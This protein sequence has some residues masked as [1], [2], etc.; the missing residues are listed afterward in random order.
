M[1][2]ERYKMSK[3]WGWAV[4]AFLMLG[5]VGVFAQDTESAVEASET[6]GTTFVEMIRQGGWTMIPLG[7]FSLGTLTFALQNFMALREKKLLRP[8]LMPTLR[9]QMA[10]RDIK[11]AL[12]TCGNE[13]MF[14][15]VLSAG[16]ERCGGADD[17]E[18][19]NVKEAIDEATTERM[20]AYMKPINYLSI[21]GAVAPMLGL[22]GTVS[23]MIKAFNTI[24]VKGMGNPAELAGNIGE[25]LVTTATGLIIA[26]PAM[27]FY[28]YFKSDF[29]KIVATMGRQLGVLLDDL[30]IGKLPAETKDHV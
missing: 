9:K 15:N 25:A 2:I 3:V 12:E 7:L 23:G 24:G 11:G 16:L 1:M 14:T 21:I 18:L 13:S 8:D 28:H 29:I 4:C 10:A 22:L 27:L 20:T 26:I 5:A 30:R 19:A 17:L 6:G